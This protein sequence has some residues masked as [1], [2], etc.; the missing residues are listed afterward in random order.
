MISKHH[1]F[2]FYYITVRMMILNKQIYIAQPQP[3]CRKSSW[4]RSRIAP[5]FSW[6][7]LSC[8]QTWWFLHHNYYYYYCPTYTGPV[9]LGFKYLWF[10][11]FCHNYK[12]WIMNYELWIIKVLIST[13]CIT[14]INYEFIIFVIIYVYKFLWLCKL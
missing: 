1:K 11:H 4:F 14:I 8:P 7:H 6:T 5:V 12:L 13:C 9:A 2:Y 3:P 10:Y